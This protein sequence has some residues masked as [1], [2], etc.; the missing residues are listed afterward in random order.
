MAMKR[1]ADL[2]AAFRDE[3]MRSMPRQYIQLL[4]ASAGAPDRGIVCNGIQTNWEFKHATPSFACPGIQQLTCMKMA[5]W[6]HCRFVIWQE[7]RAHGNFDRTLIVDP[8]AVHDGSWP[9]NFLAECEG[10]N[11]KWL[12]AHVAREHLL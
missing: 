9:Y 8:S 10:F 12:V 11:M 6:G 4:Y 3:L 2:K 1:E 5:A 7:Q